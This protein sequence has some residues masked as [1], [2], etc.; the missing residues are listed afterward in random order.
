MHVLIF[1]VK[2]FFLNKCRLFVGAVVGVYLI[3]SPVR[4]TTVHSSF[5]RLFL[6]FLQYFVHAIY[7]FIFLLLKAFCYFAG[8]F[9]M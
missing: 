8:R 9:L 4:T 3:I 6:V 1:Q 7:A 2:F 5:L